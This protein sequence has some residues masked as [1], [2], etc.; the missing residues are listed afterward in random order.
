MTIV[1]LV[2]QG[3]LLGGYYA[4]LACGLSFMFGVMKI[5]NIAHGSLAVLAA[6]MLF[7]LAEQF[8]VNPFTALL[9]VLPVMACLGWLLQRGILERSA[10]SGEIVPVL[11]TFGLAIVIENLL[12]EQFGADSRSLAPFI[13]DLSYSSWHLTGEINIG[14]LPA[15]I[16]VVAFALLGGLQLILGYT[17]LGRVIRATAEDAATVELTGINS[18]K[19]NAAAAAIALVTVGIAGMSLAMRSTFD[20]YSA[21]LQLIFAFEATVIGGIG[22]LWGTLFGGI[23][24]GVSQTLG[25]QIHPQGFLLAGHAIFMI[26]LFARQR[27]ISQIIQAAFKG[28]RK[29][30][31][32]ISTPVTSFHNVM[33]GGSAKANIYFIERWTN[34]SIAAALIVA[35]VCLVLAVAPAVVSPQVVDGLTT[36]FI[37]I[38]LAVMWNALAGYG[39][40]VSIGQ[41][42]FFGLGAY[43]AIRISEWGIS[44]YPALVIAAL[45]VGLSAL[46]MSVF[47]L[48]LRAGEFAIG[49]WVLSELLRLIVNLDTLI[50]GDTGRSLIAL[51]AYDM[52][53]RRNVTYWL[54]LGSM[55]GFSGAVFLLL[56]S[57]TGSSIQAIRD[58]EKAATS[59]GV[60]TVPTKRIIFILAAVGCAMAGTLW[61]A[62]STTFQPR[63]FFSVQWT[64]YMIFM[65]LVGGL[66]RFEGPILGAVIFFIFETLFGASGVWYLVGLGAI[67]LFFAL[68]VPRGIWGWFEDRYA[69]QLLPIGYRLLGPKGAPK[70]S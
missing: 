13:G 20:P 12:F 25:S 9:I 8:D 33:P 48:R 10:R 69:V 44:V 50:Q 30:S 53:A 65:V 60:R 40:L 66:G 14:Q 38:I 17:P 62:T 67:A 46:P 47:V 42:A 23:V 5:I 68:F 35:A 22:S 6:F 45:A 59:V 43:F 54:A 21:P 57:S 70:T 49:M 55:I 34:L 4:L 64:A 41:Q 37:Y 29:P 16:F 11:S 1:N 26:V 51:S 19:V 3:T 32:I 7:V 24:L 36:L 61:L 39:G 31:R 58:N 56:R 52:V 18:R 15:L 63:S 28:F 2:L 27:V